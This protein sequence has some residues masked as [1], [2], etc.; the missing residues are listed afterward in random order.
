MTQHSM[1]TVTQN[2]ATLPRVGANGGW[3]CYP[4]HTL[5]KFATLDDALAYAQKAAARL[6]TSLHVRDIAHNSWT[7]DGGGVSVRV[8]YLPH[9]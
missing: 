1:F 9:G 2:T 8:R 3:G 4:I 5:G 6:D 7:V